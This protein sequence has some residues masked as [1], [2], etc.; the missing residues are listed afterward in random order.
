MIPC[1]YPRPLHALTSYVINVNIPAQRYDASNALVSLRGYFL[2]YQ[3]R[4]MFYPSF[5]EVE[6]DPH[7]SSEERHVGSV[8]L[9]TFRNAAGKLQGEPP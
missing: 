6:A 4:Q 5:I 9:R 2:S 7:Y 8:T 3:G 1:S